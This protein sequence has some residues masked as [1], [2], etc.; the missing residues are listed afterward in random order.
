MAHLRHDH[1]FM[2]Q[3][4]S[5]AIWNCPPPTVLISL[6][7][8]TN[9]AGRLSHN[10]REKMVRAFDVRRK[11][12]SLL[13]ARACC[14]MPVCQLTTSWPASSGNESLVVVRLLLSSLMHICFG[15]L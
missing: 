12:P 14:A 3:I 4:V 13:S 2:P 15:D 8:R 1:R 7:E 9:K 11:S 5:S 10:T 6:L